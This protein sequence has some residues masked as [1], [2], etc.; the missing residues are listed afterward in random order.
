MPGMRPAL[1]LPLRAAPAQ[2]ASTGIALM[3]AAIFMFSLMDVTA[4]ALSARVDTVMAIWARYTGQ[5]VIVALLV[6]PRLGAV[7]RTDHPWLQGLRAL[8][9]L[10]ATTAMFLQ[11]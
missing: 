2:A 1:S 10:L 5:T 4:K 6:A 3:I 7:L 8:L 9:L 11:G